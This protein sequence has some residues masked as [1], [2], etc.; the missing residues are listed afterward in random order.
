MKDI[1]LI[2]PKNQKEYLVRITKKHMRRIVYHVRDGAIYVSAPYLCSRQAVLDSLDSVFPRLETMLSR[3]NP[4][5]ADSIYFFGEKL[6]L[7]LGCRFSV[8]P[9]GV[10]YKDQAE[11][12]KQLR[13]YLLAYLTTRVRYYEN[14]MGIEQ[15]YK[16]RVRKMESRYGS[17]SRGTHGLTFAFKLV[18]YGPSII[19]SIV[20][21]ELSHY[22]YFDHSRGF[23]QT[24]LKYFPSYRAEHAK[25]KKGLYQ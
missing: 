3:E 7:V 18:H 9:T 24:V 11:L 1:E 17:N 22:Y 10:T 15:P 20:V 8:S 2:Y 16:V 13:K 25:L 14:L 6:P 4:I 5:T 12:D 19:D 23:Y 21:H